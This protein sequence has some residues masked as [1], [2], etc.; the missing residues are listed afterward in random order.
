MK[1]KYLIGIIVVLV[2]LAIWGVYKMSGP[3][4]VVSPEQQSGYAWGSRFL[5]F[6][7]NIPARPAPTPVLVPKVCDTACQIVLANVMPPTEVKRLVSAKPVKVIPSPSPRCNDPK[8]DFNADGVVDALDIQIEI[9]KAMGLPIPNNISSYSF[10]PCF[11]FNGD[12]YITASDV[13]SVI[14]CTLG[15]RQQCSYSDLFY[16]K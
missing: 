6:I 1:K 15:N 5:N 7:N 12:Y 8:A 13:S 9:N 4:S 10:I 16:K 11:D 3:V 14:S 2:I